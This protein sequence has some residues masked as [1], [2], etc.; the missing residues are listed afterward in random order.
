M[1]IDIMEECSLHLEG[2]FMTKGRDVVAQMKRS[3]KKAW[4]KGKLLKVLLH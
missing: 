1:L 3:K 2:T 4:R